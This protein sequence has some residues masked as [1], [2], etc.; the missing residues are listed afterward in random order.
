[1]KFR[2]THLRAQSREGVVELSPHALLSPTIPFFLANGSCPK[3]AAKSLWGFF[4]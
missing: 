1:M 3:I 2:V 4:S